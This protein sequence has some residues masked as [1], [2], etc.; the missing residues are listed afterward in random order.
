MPVTPEALESALAALV[1][2]RPGSA[3]DD[4]VRARLA[5]VLADP[6]GQAWME[7]AG[8]LEGDSCGYPV[9][10]GYYDT[11]S[12]LAAAPG[13]DDAI[14]ARALEHLTRDW[15]DDYALT[16]RARLDRSWREALVDV[17]SEG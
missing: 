13:T 6:D 14:R 17:A 5:E 16:G 4:R 9:E 11:K 1:E 12:E 3:V 8:L 7:S 10:G 2:R 15:A